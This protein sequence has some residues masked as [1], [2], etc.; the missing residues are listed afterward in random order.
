MI[1]TTTIFRATARQIAA[2]RLG[3]VSVRRLQTKVSEYGGTGKDFMIGK[4]YLT[5]LKSCRCL[6]RGQKIREPNRQK[7]RKYVEGRNPQTLSRGRFTRATALVARSPLK[8]KQVP[9][10]NSPLHI[11]LLIKGTVSPEMCA[12]FA[13]RRI[14]YTCARFPA[15][16]FF[17]L[18]QKHPPPPPLTPILN[19]F[20]Y[21]FE[22]SENSKVILRIISIR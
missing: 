3:Y 11:A 6:A 17:F 1:I 15:S 16:C 5:K 18:H 19:F 22:F 4:I 14:H 12:R 20:E 21:K 10:R 8:C 2:Y 7:M 9:P 13:F